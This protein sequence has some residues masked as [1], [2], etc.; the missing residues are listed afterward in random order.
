VPCTGTIQW[1]DDQGPI[2]EIR[3][4]KLVAGKRED[5]D[6]IVREVSL[7]MLRRYGID[8]VGAA[9]SMEDDDHYVLIRSFRSPEERREQL[10]RFYGSDEWVENYSDPVGELIETYH[11]VVLLDQGEAAVTLPARIAG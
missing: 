5:F 2:L 6:R 11:T 7:P 9:P 10:E 4:Y 8:V 1:M 3:T